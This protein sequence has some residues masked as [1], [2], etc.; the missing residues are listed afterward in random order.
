MNK[1]GFTLVEMVLTIIILAIVVLSLTKIQYFMST[2]TVKIKEKSFATQKV[3]QMME[4]LRSLSSGLERD[5]INVL[6]GYDEG[7]RYNPLLT[8][9]RN[10]LNPE[11]PISNNARI[12]NG[13]KYLRRISIQRNPEETYTRKV[14]IRVY[15]ANLSNP[16]QPL[17]VLAETMSILRTI[18]QEFKPKQAFDLYVLCM[19]NVPGWWSSMSTMK[20]SFQSI[21][22]DLKTR[23]PQIDIRTHLITRLSY[24]R[25]LQYAT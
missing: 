18:S 20:P 19:E 25:D 11:N 5:Q 2:N 10:V 1:K 24:G 17:E 7:N 9:D 22:T 15:K 23:C 12:T 8:T 14:Y 21:I 16:S 3:I 6:D 4:E 13:W